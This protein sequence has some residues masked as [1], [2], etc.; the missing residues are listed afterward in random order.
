MKPEV[1]ASILGRVIPTFGPEIENK[2]LICFSQ[3][4]KAFSLKLFWKNTILILCSDIDGT[5]EHLKTEVT[6]I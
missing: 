5:V 2:Y 3:D 6:R 4:L 1:I